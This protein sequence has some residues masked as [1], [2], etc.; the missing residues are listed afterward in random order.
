MALRLELSA[1]TKIPIDLSPV[2]PAQ[3]VKLSAAD[4][5]RLPIWHGN[6]QTPLAELFKIRG[7]AADQQIEFAGDLRGVHRIG[8]RLDGGVIRVQGNAGRELGSE[9][10]GGEIVVAGD[11]GDFAGQAMRGGQIRIRGNAG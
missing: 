1:Q 7:N 2:L 9:M 6:R 10:T 4:I 5:E 3:L 8:A 11:A